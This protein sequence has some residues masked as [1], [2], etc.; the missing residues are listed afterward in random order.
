MLGAKDVKVNA[1]LIFLASFSYKPGIVTVAQLY[2][3]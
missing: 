1:N 3:Q 2:N